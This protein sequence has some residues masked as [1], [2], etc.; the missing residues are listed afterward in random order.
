MAK[1]DWQR[2]LQN[3]MTGRNGVDDCARWFM[4]IAII[5]LVIS[6]IFNF[7]NDTVASALSWL[8][9]ISIIYAYFR[10]MSRNIAKRQ[11]ENRSWV[12]KTSKITIPIRRKMALL[13]EWRMYHK[14]HHIYVCKNCG[15]SLRVP[16]GKGKVKV[17]CPKCKTTFTTKS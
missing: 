12:K 7:F 1:G 11:A 6:L 2:K 5:F 14:T 16:K 13:R 9:M 17:T 15:Q 4:G 3:W 10:M 8:A